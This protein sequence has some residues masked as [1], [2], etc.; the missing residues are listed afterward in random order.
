MFFMVNAAA[1][2]L[3]TLTGNSLIVCLKRFNM[4]KNNYIICTRC[5]MDSNVQGIHFDEDGVCDYC[6]EFV[7]KIPLYRLSAEESNH[8]LQYLADNIKVRGK[9][10]EYDSIIGLSGGVDSSYVAYLAHKLGLKPLAIHFDNGWDSE[11]AVA[12]IKKIVDKYGFDFETYVIDWPEF[13][14]LQRSFIKASVVDI[15]ML[16]DQAICAAMFHF[17]RKFKIKYILS[18]SNYATEHG[19]PQAWTWHKLDVGNIKAIH[20]RFG[21]LRLKTFPFIGFFEF[22]LTRRLGMR[23]EYIELLNDVNYKKNEAI[24][25]LSCELGWKYYGGK[26]YESV[27]TKF[28]QGYI[29]P[30]KFGIDKRRAHWSSLVRNQEITRQEALAELAKPIYDPVELKIEKEYVLKKLGFSH[31]EFDLIMKALPVGHQVYCSSWLIF[32]FFSKIYRILLK[33]N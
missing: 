27:F 22:A 32:E 33:K 31:Q 17:A 19:M 18:G 8:R 28:Y 6:R 13:R 20:R 4:T 26:H 2:S 10:R 24:D 16:T 3:I 15:E 25:A 30:H 5:V 23:F 11:I 14:D 29:L 7:Q 21:E 9:G 12:N 1:Y